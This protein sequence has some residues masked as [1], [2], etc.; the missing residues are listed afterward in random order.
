MIMRRAEEKFNSCPELQF[1]EC[2]FHFQE[3]LKVNSLQEGIWIRLAF[4][5]MEIEDWETAASAY[6]RYCMLNSEVLYFK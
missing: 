1:R 6:R 2:I 5:A 4:S 3:S